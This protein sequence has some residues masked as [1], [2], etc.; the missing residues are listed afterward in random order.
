[1]RELWHRGP[2][3]QRPPYAGPLA[4][5]KTRVFR[6][7]LEPDVAPLHRPRPADVTRH[8]AAEDGSWSLNFEPPVDRKRTSRVSNVTHL[9]HHPTTPTVRPATPAQNH[10]CA[11]EGGNA[12]PC[13]RLAPL[14]T[15]AA[16]I[17]PPVAQGTSRESPLAIFTN[18]GCVG[19]RHVREC[20][21]FA[22]FLDLLE[23]PVPGPWVSKAP[24]FPGH[25]FNFIPRL[26][27]RRISNTH[28]QPRGVLQLLLFMSKSQAHVSCSVP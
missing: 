5:H 3:S 11:P 16:T 14:G 18:Q 6:T 7:T 21:Y 28:D 2:H 27:V 4:V 19:G 26:A 20:A 25:C 1:M 12:G 8:P 23:T 9:P 13:C 24:S 10:A 22:F 15:L 17:T